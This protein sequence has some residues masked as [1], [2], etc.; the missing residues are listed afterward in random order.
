MNSNFLGLVNI[1]L[2]G[3]FK[4]GLFELRLTIFM[5]RWAET[6]ERERVQNTRGASRK[7]T[8]REVHRRFEV[9]D[10]RTVTTFLRELRATPSASRTTSIHLGENRP[11]PRFA[12][13]PARFPPSFIDDLDR[14]ARYT[15]PSDPNRR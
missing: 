9:E 10:R 2:F 13:T 14:K 5:R 7:I 12:R 3:E 15:R 11:E 6:V 4:R 8:T 1:N